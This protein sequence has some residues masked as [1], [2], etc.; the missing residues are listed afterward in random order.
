LQLL[1]PLAFL[2]LEYF[3]QRTYLS[4]TISVT[5]EEM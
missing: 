1:Q 2:I 4:R 5:I 3:F